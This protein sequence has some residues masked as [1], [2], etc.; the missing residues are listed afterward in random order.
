MTAPAARLAADLLSQPWGSMSRGELDFVV[1]RFLVE[2]GHVDLSSPDFEIAQ[3]LLTTPA[4][5]KALRFRIEQRNAKLGEIDLDSLIVPRNFIFAASTEPGWIR[6]RTESDYLR[7]RLQSELDA[8]DALSEQRFDA[9]VLNVPI[10]AFTQALHNVI[11]QATISGKGSA[12]TAEVNRVFTRF[13]QLRSSQRR[14]GLLTSA[15]ETTTLAANLGTILQAALAF[16][17]APG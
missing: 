3:E 9:K 12:A 6:V 1:F 10:E 16:V 8:L 11:N 7:R 4:R 5:I 15:R 17:G 14:S 2:D 13:E